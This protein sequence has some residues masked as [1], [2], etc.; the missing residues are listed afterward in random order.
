MGDTSFKQGRP[1]YKGDDDGELEGFKGPANLCSHGGWGDEGGHRLSRLP[2]RF[3]S[4]STKNST[5]K[6]AIKK[7]EGFN[8]PL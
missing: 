5:H 6:L 4:A 8:L 7:E 1:T 3:T 2:Q